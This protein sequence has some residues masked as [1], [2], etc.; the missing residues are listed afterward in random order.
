MTSIDP[1][2]YMPSPGDPDWPHLPEIPR[3]PPMPR[4][5][6]LTPG[7]IEELISEYVA[8][9]EDA[10]EWLEE[11]GVAAAIAERRHKERRDQRTLQASAKTVGEREV[12]GSYDAREEHQARLVTAALVVSMADAIRTRRAVLDSLRT[13]AANARAAT[14]DGRT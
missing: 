1:L 9:L 7:E 5:R 3:P 4:G 14:Y 10:T 8:W 2:D 13:L 12:R 11:R 6:P